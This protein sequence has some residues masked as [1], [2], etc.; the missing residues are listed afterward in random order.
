M[1]KLVTTI[2]IDAVTT[3]RVVL[4]P[5]L[6]SSLRGNSVVAAACTDDGTKDKR[7]KHTLDEVRVVKGCE[8]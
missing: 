4:R 1:R 3:T 7:F 2:N 5:P 6:R 8:F